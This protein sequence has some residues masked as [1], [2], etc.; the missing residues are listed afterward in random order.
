MR[1][2]YNQLKQYLNTTLTPTEI[3]NALTMLGL[4]IEEVI[5]KKTP[6]ADFIVAEIVECENHPD[7][8]HLH[9]L[10]VNTGNEVID[11]VCGAPNA[12]KG[13]KGILARP[14]NIIPSDGTKLKAGQVRGKPSNGMM[15]SARELGLG[16]DHDG[17]IELP[18]T[19]TAGQ[20]AISALKDIYP[21]DIIYEG[22]VLPNHPDYLGI[23]G[24]ARDLSA[25]GF[26]EL[27]EPT[28]KET[29]STYPSPI[30]VINNI[31]ADAQEF[32]TRYIKDVENKAS[33]SWLKNYLTSVDMKSISA[34]VDI[35]NFCLHNINRPLHVFDADKIKGDLVIDYA[36]GGEEFLALD[37]NTYILNKGD[38]VI[39]DDNGIQSLAGVMGG[40][41][42]SCTMETKNVLLESAY[43][44]P[45]KIR[46]TAKLLKIESDSKFRFER[47]IDKCSTIWGM[48]YATNL[49]T[50]I[51]G[52]T[53]SEICK[54]GKCEFKEYEIT[55]PINYFEKLIGFNI[56]K[57]EMISILTK[58]GCK[59]ID[60]GE[61][62]L[63][64]PPSYRE[65]L[66]GPHDITEE[67]VRI[68][69]FE[70]LPSVS[71]ASE[72][73]NNTIDTAT[74]RKI[75]LPHLLASRGLT[76]VYTFSF[77]SDKKEFDN[78]NP[79]KL[80]NP[81]TS[82]LNVLRK[83]II[84]NLLD[85]IA[86]NLAHSINSSHLFEMGP[87]FY[88]SKPTEQHLYISG[89]RQG[90]N[91]IQDWSNKVST[92]DVYDAKNDVFAI[93]KLFGVSENSVKFTTENLPLWLN[94]YKSANV[95]FANKVIGFIGEVHPLTLK[96]FGIKN[97]SV[98][99]FEINLDLLPPPKDKK[100]T[101][102]KKL[103]ISEL[104]PL[105]RDFAV[106]IDDNIEGEKILS[107]V[108]SAN[109]EFITKA[110]IFDI[111][112]GENVPSGKKS[113]AIHITITQKDKTLTDE[114]IN[115]IFKSAIDK[116]IALGGILRDK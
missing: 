8:D 29:K 74:I 90:S 88:G 83:S 15:C 111:Y 76:E 93:L 82:D 81:I 107:A 5:D 35:T 92:P 85:G 39:R 91:I 98:V 21:L 36:I 31:T 24:I 28:I 52:G 3:A 17:I 99:A 110:T 57:S 16:E 103:E 96:K 89:V 48:E 105:G 71:V 44:N 34:L 14:G 62:L 20:D 69:G 9:L 63:I 22:N 51:C 66:E 86:K 53:P 7:S 75:K 113:I 54:T 41:A 95:V 40:L 104:A 23:L 59:V 49:I 115:S 101:A 114:E 19:T 33:P 84:P 108:K 11:V 94:P 56:E 55:F 80:I 46:K 6:L 25:G 116:V 60:K 87:V 112:K 32:N 37:G 26:G 64:T 38:I 72:S 61:T 100:T 77:M 18:S 102:K 42:T 47:G 79:I 78:S 68:Y 43:F 106:I 1:F 70:K 2:T 27:I 12:K 109:K 13:L 67:L 50:D 58:L 65:D 73:I 97:T 30:N 45:V 4:E 10:K